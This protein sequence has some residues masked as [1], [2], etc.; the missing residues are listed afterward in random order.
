MSRGRRSS[1]EM[2]LVRMPGIYLIMAL[3]SLSDWWSWAQMRQPCWWTS[4][5]RAW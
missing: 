2:R 5:H 4:R 3:K 1:M